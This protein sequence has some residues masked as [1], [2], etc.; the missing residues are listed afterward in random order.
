[1]MSDVLKTVRPGRIG[2]V[3]GSLLVLCLVLIAGSVAGEDFKLL[4]VRETG[5]DQASGRPAG[6]VVVNGGYI[7]GIEKG[8]TG[9]I[10]RKNKYKGQLEVADFTV[11]EVAPY[12]VVGTFVLR[13]PDL[14]VQKKDR[15]T[16]TVATHSDADV[17]ARAFE[18]LDADRCFDAL[19]YFEK[20]LCANKENDFVLK[21]VEEC[22]ARV[23]KKLT[24][25]TTTGAGHLKQFDI[26]EQLEVAEGLHEYKNDLAADLYLKRIYSED[27]TLTKAKELRQLVPAQDFSTLLSPQHCK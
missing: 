27:S 16:L 18:S 25:G 4:L 11:V 10:W 8:M 23:E 7:D 17:V 21:R 26:W 22:R 14:Y 2:F 12:E 20:I 6:R 3:G 13:Y 24:E 19:L 15:I 5:V 9:V 1:M